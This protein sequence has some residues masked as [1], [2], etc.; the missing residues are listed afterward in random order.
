M[1]Y[2]GRIG[3]SL[4]KRREQAVEDLERLSSER[5]ESATEL[6]ETLN[7]FLLAGGDG[8]MLRVMTFALTNKITRAQNHTDGG[9]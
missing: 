4:R 9:E 3:Q 5:P 1:T 6:I 8:Q 7:R 2:N